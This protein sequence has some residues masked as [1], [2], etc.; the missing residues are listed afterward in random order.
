MGSANPWI[1]GSYQEFL[2]YN[3]PECEYKSKELGHFHQHAVNVHELAKDALN[4]IEVKE[5][6][7]DSLERI[8]ESCGITIE[9]PPIKKSSVEDISLCDNGE[10]C[11][12]SA[13]T[14]SA[15]MP[16]SLFIPS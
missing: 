14:N 15:I 2:F 10:V 9:E 3:C 7:K 5:S 8:I 13:M 1:V 16:I 6:E 11:T 12:Q 4:A